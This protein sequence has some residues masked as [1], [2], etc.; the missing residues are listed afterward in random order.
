MLI[1][2][3]SFIS[4]LIDVAKK[5]EMSSRHAA[6]VL[7]GKRILAISP[8]NRGELKHNLPKIKKKMKN[9]ALSIHAEEC[10]L[11]KIQKM[12]L[13]RGKLRIFVIR[14]GAEYELLQSK[15]CSQC[16]NFMRLSRI[17]KV[18]YSN[19]IGDLITESL[20]M[21]TG[22]QTTSGTNY[23]NSYVSSLD[24]NVVEERE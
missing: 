22:A 16:I 4:S 8:N 3:N 23:I 17:K 9:L 12:N 18:T 7:S 10:V 13:P 2:S 11:H 5:S 20:G 19:E 24:N 15:P 6:A 1:K 14:I 21:I